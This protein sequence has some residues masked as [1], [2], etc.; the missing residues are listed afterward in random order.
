MRFQT[1]QV[2]EIARI[3][4]DT[5]R[6]WKRCIRPIS[7]IDGRR[8]QYTLA[9]VAGICMISRATQGLGLPIS[10]F[11]EHAT[12][13]FK[14]LQAQLPPAGTPL[15]L[16]IVP[17]KMFFIDESALVRGDAVVFIRIRPILEQLFLTLQQD[18]SPPAAQLDLPFEDAKVR[19]LPRLRRRSQPSR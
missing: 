15:V 8:R 6:T 18:T 9:E 14:Q 12:D 2:L 5:L 1:A 3:G 19:E 10:Q 16:C 17:R 13:L 11:S 7:H 4:K